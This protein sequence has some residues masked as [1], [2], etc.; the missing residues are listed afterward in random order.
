MRRINALNAS[1]EQF[2]IGEFYFPEPFTCQLQPKI[3]IGVKAL[4]Y[5]FTHDAD[6]S[7][8]F[9]MPSLAPIDE[10][11]T[12][13]STDGTRRVL[14]GRKLFSLSRRRFPGTYVGILPRGAWRFGE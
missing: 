13:T 11:Q 10:E 6:I 3:N 1:T 12:S 4:P 7:E 9:D 14:R 8:I 5:I 2:S